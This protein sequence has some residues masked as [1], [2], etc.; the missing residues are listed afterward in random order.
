M[1]EDNPGT[2]PVKDTSGTT[3]PEIEQGIL[4]GVNIGGS[5]N[6]GSI[7]QIVNNQNSRENQEVQEVLASSSQPLLSSTVTNNNH[8]TFKLGVLLGGVISFGP[9]GAVFGIL[10]GILSNGALGVSDGLL[11]GAVGGG[12]FGGLIAILSCI[13]KRF[14]A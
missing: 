13:V 14:G 1:A 2:D 10:L 5:V 12:M 8:F 3:N 11:F 7:N 9:I 4:T 6:I